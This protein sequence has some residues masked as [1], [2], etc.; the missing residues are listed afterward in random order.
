MNVIE[1]YPASKE[2]IELFDESTTFRRALSRDRKI[3][4][5]MMTSVKRNH[6]VAQAMVD[7]GPR[8][9][10]PRNTFIPSPSRPGIPMF[11]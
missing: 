5:L 7:A 9:S 1:P 11:A 3:R 2:F 6:K 10:S 4:P 8:I